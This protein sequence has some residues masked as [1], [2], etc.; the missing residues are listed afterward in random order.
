MLET[1]TQGAVNGDLTPETESLDLPEDVVRFRSA[2]QKGDVIYVNDTRRRLA[3]FA[4]WLADCG[5]VLGSE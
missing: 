2:L 5:I 4:Q 1:L 3:D